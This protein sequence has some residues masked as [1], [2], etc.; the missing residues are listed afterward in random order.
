MTNNKHRAGGALRN[1]ASR[2]GF[3]RTLCFRDIPGSM[4][5]SASTPSNSEPPKQVVSGR[6]ASRNPSFAL[7]IKQP[8]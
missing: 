5:S 3:E 1:S 7:H 6:V 2:Q 4:P 8:V